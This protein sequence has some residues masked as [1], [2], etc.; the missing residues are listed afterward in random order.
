MNCKEFLELL[1]DYLLNKVKKEEKNFFEEHLKKCANCKKELEFEYK[2]KS[3]FKNIVKCDVPLDFKEKILAPIQ[4]NTN[5]IQKK[6]PVFK[7][8]S[9]LLENNTLF[10]IIFGFLLP[11]ILSPISFIIYK[12]SGKIQKFIS[13]LEFTIS[14]LS[15]E[16]ILII[17]FLIATSALFY[18]VRLTLKFLK[19]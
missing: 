3:A 10:W 11:F 16:E 19:H 14:S 4:R 17:N 2:I 18:G 15:T 8:F 13:Q 6:T 12:S 1:N 9:T 7:I 5:Y